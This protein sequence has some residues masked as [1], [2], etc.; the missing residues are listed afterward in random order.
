M[1]YVY[2]ILDEVR[3]GS[4]GHVCRPNGKKER[5]RSQI[6]RKIHGARHFWDTT[7]SYSCRTWFLTLEEQEVFRKKVLTGPNG[8]EL[9]EHKKITSEFLFLICCD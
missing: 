6:G 5:N 7:K 4:S 9:A 3:L 2:D 1:R 8:G